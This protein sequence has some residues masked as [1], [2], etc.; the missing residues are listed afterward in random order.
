MATGAPPIVVIGTTGDPATP[1]EYAENMADQLASG[2]LVTF[3]GEGHLAYGQQRVHRP[4]RRQLSDGRPGARRPDHLLTRR[5]CASAACRCPL[6]LSKGGNPSSASTSTALRSLD[7][8]GDRA[9]RASAQRRTRRLS[10]DGRAT[11]S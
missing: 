4:D 1:Y 9:R 5:R 6:S 2:V 10:S 3:N 7:I 11:H 8:V